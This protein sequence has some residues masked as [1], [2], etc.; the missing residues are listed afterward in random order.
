MNSK[1]AVDIV[2]TWVDYNDPIWKADYDRFVLGQNK[3]NG[4]VAGKTRYSAHSTLKYLFRG[5]E[6]Y[7]SWFNKVY[8]VT[9]GH[10]PEWLNLNFEK[11]IIVKHSDFIPHEY[12]P[13]FNS[14]TILLNL[15]RI[16]GLS[17]HFILFND[18]MY[19][20]N[21]CEVEHFFKKGLP[22]DLAVQYPVFSPNFDPFW[23][24]MLNNMCLINRNFDK[25]TTIKNHVFK[26]FNFKYGFKN[27]VRNL[28]HIPYKKFS[29][30]YDCHLPNAHLKSVYDE[31]WKKEFDACNSTCLNRFRTAN[32]ITEWTMKYWQLAS[33]KF[34]PLNKTKMGVY[35]SLTSNKYKEIFNYKY[36]MK[37]ICLNDESDDMNYVADV[38]EQRLS[39]K[40]S[41]EK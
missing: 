8:F 3:D 40:S 28:C 17:E 31:V 7:A 2:L 15:H 30:F 21:Y 4:H 24:M 10:V 29:G 37:L 1:Y 38:F 20:T 22:C 11:L 5:I 26:W 14:N 9:Y 33:N 41:F 16:K 12:L 27:V 36:K 23:D 25:K 6:K 13:T 19:F 35:V 34:Y 32:D 18:D 39:E